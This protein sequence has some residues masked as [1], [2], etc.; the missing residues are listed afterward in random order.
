LVGTKKYQL[1]TQEIPILDSEYQWIKANQINETPFY[2]GTLDLQEHMQKLRGNIKL[3]YPPMQVERHEESEVIEDINTQIWEYYAQGS[4]FDKAMGK[5]MIK[6]EITEEFTK[7]Q[8]ELREF[9]NNFEMDDIKKAYKKIDIDESETDKILRLK[10]I[11]NKIASKLINDCKDD[12]CR[13]EI[14]TLT[15]LPKLCKELDDDE[16]MTKC[17]IKYGFF[18]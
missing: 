6:L 10:L 14:I 2:D 17:I 9:K 8:I 18:D 3:L 7:S 12:G 13:M 5:I 1:T 16:E 11:E 4:L 15:R